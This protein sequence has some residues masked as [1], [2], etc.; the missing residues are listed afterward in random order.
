[1]TTGGLGRMHSDDP[2]DRAFA[3]RA[4]V[5]VPDV[6]PTS[7]YCH[8]PPRLF[9]LDQGGDPHCVGYA[10]RGLL[11]AGPIVNRGGPDARTIYTEAQ[12]RDEWE[13][14]AYAGTSARG[15]MKYLQEQGL[16]ESY[17]W[18]WSAE[19]IRLWHLTTNRPTLLGYNW[20]SSFNAPTRDG[21]ISIG[22]NAH[23]QGGH[24]TLSIGWDDR[25]GAARCMNSWGGWGQR[26]RF[27]IA[28]ETLERLL[29]ED[30]D[31]VTP[32]ERREVTT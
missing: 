9:P 30:G 22:P 5:T 11:Y 17:V 1:M 21:F 16:I 18:A 13:G 23:I 14:E 7:R 12:K 26:G 8:V 15:A 2:R 4:F 24:E 27:W 31:C 29:Q 20:Y 6:L 10:S 32:I 28:G 19:T 3:M 25:R